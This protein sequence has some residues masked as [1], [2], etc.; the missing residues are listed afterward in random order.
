MT[1][2]RLDLITVGASATVRDALHAI[3]EGAVEI[4]LLVED[5][6]LLG[7][8]SDGDIRRALLAGAGLADAVAPFATRD[9]VSVKQGEDR[10]AVLD[11]MHAR[12]I[13]QIPV[14]DDGGRLLGL[15]VLR[16]LLGGPRLDVLA[17]VL[18]GGLGSRLRPITDSVPKPMLPV[19]GRPL[20]ERLVL[21]LVGEGVTEVVLA[22]NYLS[23]VIE[24]HFGDGSR[25]GCSIS[26]VR[27]EPERPLGTA[28]CLG[29]VAGQ[30]GDRP[31]LALNGDLLLQFSVGAMLAAHQGAWATVGVRPYSH[32]VPFGVLDVDAGRVRAVREKPV[33]SWPVSGGVYVL[34]AE[35]VSAVPAG[36]RMDMPE[37]LSWG[38]EQGRTVSAHALE[39]DWI[40]VGRPE[41]LLRARGQL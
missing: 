3:N 31:L 13:S 6:R 2:E 26:Y 18:A 27:E 30:L 40:D 28:G 8:L 4:A 14:L 39:G 25:F 20:L 23:E 24:S 17:L 15:H 22:V 16:D 38:L 12:S 29:Q 1:D 35:A 21:H 33:E 7:T 19:A 36:Q 32:V 5:G 41:D 9:F 10:A 34:S 11:L 37:L